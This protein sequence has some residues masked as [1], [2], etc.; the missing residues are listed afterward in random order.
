M[1]YKKYQLHSLHEHLDSLPIYFI[2]LFWICVAHLLSF[3][4]FV[5]HRF[6]S[7]VL[8][9][10]WIWIVHNGFPLRLSLTCFLY[11]KHNNNISENMLFKND[12]GNIKI[13]FSKICYLRTTI[14]FTFGWWREGEFCLDIDIICPL[15]EA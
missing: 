2:F 1:S 6:V 14:I 8:C 5:C 13:V 9:C 15:V 7:C 12:A 4:C 3:L 10:L 11:R